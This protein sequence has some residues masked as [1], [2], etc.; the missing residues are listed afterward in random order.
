MFKKILFFVL[1]SGLSYSQEKPIK[2]V[3]EKSPNR[4]SIY[5][6]NQSETDYDVKITITGTNIRQSSAKPRLI[7]VPAASKVL[8]KNLIIA[9]GKQPRYSYDLFINDSLSKRVLK[10]PHVPIKIHP[11]K[12]IVLYITENCTKCDTI[13]SNL[14]NSNY[15]FTSIDLTQNPEDKKRIESYLINDIPSFDLLTNPIINLGGFLYT[16]LEDYSSLLEAMNQ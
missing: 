10:P 1:I 11:K 14:K 6:F 8:L 15:I 4:L 12:S 13:L 9:R 7:R 5:A 2:I 3:D 16:D